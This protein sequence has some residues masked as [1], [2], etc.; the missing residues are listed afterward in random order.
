MEVQE[1]V[2]EAVQ[3]IVEEVQGEVLQEVQKSGV[4]DQLQGELECPCW[5]L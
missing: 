2:L 5:G 4:A 3:D 1:E